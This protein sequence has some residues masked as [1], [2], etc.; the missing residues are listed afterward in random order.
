MLNGWCEK[1]HDRD[2]VN[3]RECNGKVSMEAQDRYGMKENHCIVEESLVP[4]KNEN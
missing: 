3:K 2:N 1:K 4:F